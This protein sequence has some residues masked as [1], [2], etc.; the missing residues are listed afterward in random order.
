MKNLLRCFLIG[1]KNIIGAENLLME[2]IEL[3]YLVISDQM[4]YYISQVDIYV[5]SYLYHRVSLG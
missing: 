5:F 3:Y 1:V 4:T 2:Y